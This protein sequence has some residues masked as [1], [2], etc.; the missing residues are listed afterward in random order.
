MSVFELA[1]IGRM[2]DEFESGCEEFP[3]CLRIAPIPHFPYSSL[4]SFRKTV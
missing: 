3:G 2:V 4:R 1:H